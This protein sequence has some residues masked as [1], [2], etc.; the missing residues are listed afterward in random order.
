M[1]RPAFI[2]LL[3]ATATVADD[4]P[5]VS[6]ACVSVDTAPVGDPAREFTRFTVR[7]G[8]AHPV[9]VALCWQH[10]MPRR[11]DSARGGI[12]VE[13]GPRHVIC[14]RR[15]VRLGAEWEYDTGLGQAK[16][17]GQHWYLACK[18]NSN[19]EDEFARIKGFCNL[20]VGED[21]VSVSLGEGESG[22][23]CGV[24]ETGESPCFE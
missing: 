24:L 11:W 16:P 12:V 2:A 20:R 23:G 13:K 15:S 8:C 9:F 5:E 14:T 10:P 4:T 18:Q 19:S 17:D 22:V 21:E 6:N 3:I 7:N 1:T